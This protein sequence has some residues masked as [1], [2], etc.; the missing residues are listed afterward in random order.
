M[1]ILNLF[2]NI[3]LFVANKHEL[4]HFN[5]TTY[6]FLIPPTPAKIPTFYLL[7]KI[8]KASK[9]GRFIISESDVTLPE[10]A[11]CRPLPKALS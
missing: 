10:Y 7:P 3:H 6:K 2:I 1:A 5:Y 11:L 8:D 4:V 9:P